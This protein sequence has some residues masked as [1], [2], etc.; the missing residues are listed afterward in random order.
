[1]EEVA[2]VRRAALDAVDDVEPGRLRDRIRERLEDGS[3]APGVLTMLSAR[4]VA[5]RPDPSVESVPASAVA[6]RG[7]GVQLI[8]EG[9]RLTRTL[10]Q[11]APWERDG[12]AGTADDPEVTDGGVAASVD[13]ANPD[14]TDDDSTDA[15]MAI[16][17]ADVMVAR[18]FYLLA[19]TE[20]AERAVR[21]VQVFGRDQTVRRTTGDASLDRNLEADVF[22]LAVVAGTTAVGGGAPASLREYVSQLARDDRSPS[23]ERALSVADGLFSEATVE[24]LSG[25]LAD[26]S[27]D[28]VPSSADS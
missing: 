14:S 1:M 10:S 27:G 15:D 19:R 7:A 25:H 3:I 16:L 4:A 12:P 28:G 6:D 21:T 11:A 5:D 18:G 24:T 13:Q 20:A 23:A 22:E 8:Y 17:V 2:A 9:L 26:E